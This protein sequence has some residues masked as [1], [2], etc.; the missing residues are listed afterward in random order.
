MAKSYSPDG[1][2]HGSTKKMK[3]E[4]GV[5]PSLVT[6]DIIKA[7]FGQTWPLEKCIN[8]MYFLD[9]Y[10]DIDPYEI[11]AKLPTNPVKL[12]R[13]CLFRIGGEDSQLLK[14]QVMIVCVCVCVCLCVFGGR[15]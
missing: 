15:G 2:V 10:R 4:K 11:R 12:S 13:L 7:V 14:V 3:E 1:A 8:I 6:Y 9:K 5:R